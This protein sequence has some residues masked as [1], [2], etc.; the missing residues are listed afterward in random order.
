MHTVIVRYIDEAE[1][2][3][4]AKATGVSVLIYEN[5]YDGSC[6]L[7]YPNGCI[8]QSGGQSGDGFCY[9]HQSFDCTA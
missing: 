5:V 1:A 3:E 4:K 6:M 2:L 8:A 7:A 9:T